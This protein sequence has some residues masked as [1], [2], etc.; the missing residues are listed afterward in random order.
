M[1]NITKLSPKLDNTFLK[2]YKLLQKSKDHFFITGQAGTG[3]STL[4]NYFVQNSNKNIAILAPTG[5][6]AVNVGGQTIHSF[7][8]FPLNLLD[9]S[10]IKVVPNNKIYKELDTII[11]DEV[12]MV[13]ADLIDAMDKFLRLN[14]KSKRK[15][16]GGIQ[17]IFVGDLFQLPPVLISTERELF[18]QK[19]QT[20]YFLSSQA[21]IDLEL[22]M[23]EL[24]K[25][26]RQN[27]QFFIDILN[28]VRVGKVGWNEINVLNRNFQPDF[29]PKVG[30][31][32]VTL[33]TTN[34]QA[35]MINGEK[36]AKI[37]KTERQ[38][39]AEVDGSFAPK[40]FPNEE[41]LKLK[42]GAQVLFIKNDPKKRWVNGTLGKILKFEKNRVAVL[43]ENGIVDVESETWDMTKYQLN[44]VN[45]RVEAEIIG[46]FQQLPIKLAWAITI[47]KSQGQTFE[48][49]VLDITGGA[50][51]HGQIYVALSRCATLQ[52]LVLKRKVYPAAI[53]VDPEVVVFY[54]EIKQ[55]SLI[56]TEEIEN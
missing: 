41:I 21:F 12:S 10:Q 43:T 6:A 18:L 7:F 24:T 14:G 25:I 50:F 11:I 47:H 28:K 39:E 8:K 4:L 42:V 44:P 29:E 54:E 23:V 22:K 32:Y 30:E 49:V 55:K 1:S 34:R 38:F 15:S 46:T 40:S 37:A 51:A 36:L 48:K 26:Y 19:Y 9:L 20:A 27:D 35:D 13:R 33:T 45:N 2:I 3:K 17:M 16:F 31:F 5:L 53:I 52:G 56:K